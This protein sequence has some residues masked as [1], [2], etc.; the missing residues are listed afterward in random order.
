MNYPQLTVFNY[1]ISYYLIRMYLLFWLF[2]LFQSYQSALKS[3]EFLYDPIVLTFLK[4]APISI[5]S[6]GFIA[7]FCGTLAVVSMFKQSI[8]LNIALFLVVA[9]VNLF[10]YS[11][12]KISHTNHLLV[13]SLFFSIFLLPKNLKLSDYKNVQ[14]FYLGLLLTYSIAGFWKLVAIFLD[15]VKNKSQVSWAEFGAAKINTY[16][17]FYVIDRPIPDWMVQFYQHETFWLWITI[18]AVFLQFFSFLG[19]FNRKYLNI[20]M[21][22]LISM[23]V[24]NYYFVLADFRLTTIVVLVLFFPYHLLYPWLKKYISIIN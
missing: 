20:T 14:F 11:T 23:H 1:K 10:V 6:F 4:S 15:I 3:P 21:L 5:F 7:V 13:L 8:W 18:L 9:I 19:A 16:A 12:Y 24:Y 2:I 22:F 17:N